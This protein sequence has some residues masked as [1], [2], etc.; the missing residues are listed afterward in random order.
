MAPVYMAVTVYAPVSVNPRGAPTG[1][2]GDSHSFLTSH[3]GGYDN[4]VLTQGQF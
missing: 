4:G 3:P 2:P 1:N